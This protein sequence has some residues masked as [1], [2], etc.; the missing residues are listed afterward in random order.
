MYRYTYAIFILSH[1]NPVFYFFDKIIHYW[2]IYS[3]NLCLDKDLLALVYL[4]TF[5][6]CCVQQTRY[7]KPMLVDQHWFDV[8]CLLR[9]C[10]MHTGI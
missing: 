10:P 8:S 9:T 4:L 2:Y 5:S 6:W 1:Y 7:I 3:S